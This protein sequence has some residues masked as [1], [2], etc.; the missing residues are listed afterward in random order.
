MPAEERK[1]DIP[2]YDYLIVGGGSAG[3]V[4]ANRLSANADNRVLLLEAGP[5]TPPGAVP[6]AVLDAYPS[7]AYFNSDWHWR[8][9]RVHYERLLGNAPAPFV[10]RRYEQ[11]KIMGGGS[12]INGMMAI[13]GLPWDFDDWVARGAEGWSFDDVLPYYRRCERDLDYD[14]PLHGA[15]GPL[16]IRRIREPDWPGFARAARRAML[17]QGFTELEDHNGEFADGLFPMA[18]NNRPTG[19]PDGQ[20]VSTAVAYLDEATRA[21]TNLEIWP[22]CQV[23]R[24]NVDGRRATGV[25]LRRG[26]QRLT[27]E[28]R[29]TVICCG[30]FHSPAMLMRSGIG[31]GHHLRA[32]GIDVVADRAGVGQGLQD[33]PTVT[34]IAHAKHA[35]RMPVAMRRHI[36][37]GLRYSSGHDDCPAGDMFALANNR[38][39]WHP[40]GRLLAGFVVCVNKPFS[41]GEVTLKGPDADLEPVV[42]FNQFADRRDLDR[43][44]DA[45]RLAHRLMSTTTVRTGIHGSFPSTFSEKARDLAIVSSSNWLKTKAA[46][47][48]LDFPATRAFMMDRFISPGVK[49]DSL[50]ADDAALTEWVRDRACGSWHASCTCRIGRPDDAKAVVDPSCRVI[51]VDGLAVVDASVMPCVV[52][53]NTNLS[54]IMVAEKA[55]DL[56]SHN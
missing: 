30:A 22:D 54:T 46:A 28:A 36:H 11:A 26:G 38:G 33:H 55:A 16:P 5:D 35:W 43:L 4:L 15:D 1:S 29:Q 24:I 39:G 21:R 56:L 34:L 3:A 17:E 12:S 6:S 52:S 41:E 50:I 48:L 42:N 49:I 44:A 9:L 32:H 31:P 45:V 2:I 14:G 20:R 10:P 23:E 53:A 40:L 51:G 18:I 27:V 19:G 37:L 25:G 13:R 47:L 8:D 7:V